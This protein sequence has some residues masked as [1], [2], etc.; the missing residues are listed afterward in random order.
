MTEDGCRAAENISKLDHVHS[1]CSVSFD[2]SYVLTSF[3]TVLFATG[4]QYTINRL[5]NTID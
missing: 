1:L 4:R 5:R 2:V 3:G